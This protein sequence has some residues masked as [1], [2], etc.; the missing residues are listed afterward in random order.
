M[1]KPSPGDW[2]HSHKENHQ[3]YDCYKLPLYNEVTPQRKT[4]YLQQFGKFNLDFIKQLCNFCSVFYPKM[5][6][7]TLPILEFEKELATIKK[8]TNYYGSQYLAQ[9]ILAYMEKRV[10]K[11]AYCVMGITLK[12]IYPGDN[13]N[14]VYGWAK[15]KARVGIFSFLRWDDEFAGGE[16]NEIDWQ[17]IL[18][19][20]MRTMVH[21]IGHMFGITHCV[22]NRCLMN[23]FNHI[24]ENYMNPL[25]FCPV[26]YRKIAKNI[27]FDHA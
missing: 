16:K 25:E 26:C 17:K 21:E 24:D 8:R 22:Y 20:S 18:Y 9:D 3:A 23:G 27:G 12:D 19:P 2:L 6:V 15:Y 11:D 4:I 10:P 7:K 1:N 5:E 13:W 14:Y